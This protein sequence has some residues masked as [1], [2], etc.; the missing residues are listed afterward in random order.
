MEDIISPDRIQ[1]FAEMIERADKISIV[2]HTRPDGDAIGSSIALSGFIRSAYGKDTAVTVANAWS[3]SLDFIIDDN[4]R[5]RLFRHDTD[6]EG[7]ER[8]LAESDLLICIDCNGF[9]RTETLRP[10]LEASH[11]E[12]ALVDH[13]LN[14]HTEDFGVWFSTPEISSACELLYWIMMEM[15]GID[16]VTSRIPMHSLEALMSG[17]TTDTN[18]FSNSV[19]PSTL[20]M[21]SQMLAAGV[22]RDRIISELYNRYREN[23]M[24][25]IGYALYK[26]M[27]VLP[28]GLA[29]IILT[30]EELRSMDIE[31]GELEG[32]VNIPLGMDNVRMSLL[33]KEDDGYFRVSLRSKTGTSANRFASAH[34]NGGGHE[35]ASGGRLYFPRDI[36]DRSMAEEYVRAKAFEFFMEG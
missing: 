28:E 23:R 33:M 3:S 10:L 4:D 34:F 30:A 11:A 8:R 9:D 31:E 7:T 15:P 17:M 2:T 35:L 12:K 21:S 36:A 16:G 5:M 6:K 27:E 1:L 24:R 14:P 13:H 25:M 32:L 29:Y 18:N 20:M 26:K 19:W 22:D